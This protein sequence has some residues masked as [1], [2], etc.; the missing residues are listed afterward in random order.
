MLA[1]VQFR[2]IEVSSKLSFVKV[3]L[4]VF[5][6]DTAVDNIELIGL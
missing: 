5:G 3:P 1:G 2:G 4:S 6:S